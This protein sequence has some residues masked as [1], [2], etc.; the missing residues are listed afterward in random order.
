M[1]DDGGADDGAAEEGPARG[2]F[3]KDEED[4]DGIQDRF[5]VTNNA[6]VQRTNT[7]R[8]RGREKRVGDADLDDAEIGDADQIVSGD[9]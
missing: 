6:R 4:P 2:A 1:A 8:H 7:A 9:R 3:A 5:D